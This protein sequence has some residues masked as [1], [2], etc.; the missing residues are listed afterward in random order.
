[1]S[2]LYYLWKKVTKFN[3]LTLGNTEGLHVFL[4]SNI[5]T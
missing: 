1:M 4:T 2:M 5:F 3:L